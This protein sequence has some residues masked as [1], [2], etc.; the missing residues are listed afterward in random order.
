MKFFD[1]IRLSRI[2]TPTLI[3]SGSYDKDSKIC[4]F[5]FGFGFGADAYLTNPFFREELIA[6]IHAIIRRSKG[7]SQSVIWTRKVGFNLDIKTVEVDGKTAHLIGKEYQ[8]LES[9]SL[10]KGKH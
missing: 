4:G 1:K 7:H 5:G 8:V 6:K 2:E 3:L 9:P 10:R